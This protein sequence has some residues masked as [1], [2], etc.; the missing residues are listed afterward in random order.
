M[1]NAAT[2]EEELAN[3]RG[4]TRARLAR[5]TPAH[6]IKGFYLRGYL[7][8]CRGQGGDEL[9]ERCRAA[10]KERQ[11]LDFMSYPYS[12]ALE[13]SLVGAE[14]LVT[15]FG[16]VRPFL[17]AMGRIAVDQYLGSPLGR[18]FLSLAKPSPKAM[19]RMLPTAIATTIRFGSRS[20]SIEGDQ[21][22]VFA[23]RDDFS[24]AE[25]NAGAIEA[26][27]IAGR[28]GS[29]SVRVKAFSLLDYDLEASWS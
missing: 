27:I 12:A 15:K 7:E 9:Y 16:G 10:V 3:F 24:P 14:V 1:E 25:A 18:T 20:V 29:P 17:R 28:G 13:I 8:A 4:D 22:A 23:C 5:V 2:I 21:R 26:V 11:I 19:L 6:T